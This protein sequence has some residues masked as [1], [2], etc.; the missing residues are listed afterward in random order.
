V[1]GNAGTL[2]VFRLS[3][4]D[5]EL[6][7]PEFHLLPAPE[8]PDQSPHRRGS[9]G[10]MQVADRFS[11]NRHSIRRAAVATTLWRKADATSTERGA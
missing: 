2:I 7:A 8:L 3:S 6:L 4:N 5:A 9:D 1:L 10:T 11:L